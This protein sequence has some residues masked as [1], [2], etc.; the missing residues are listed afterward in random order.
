M[1]ISI[2]PSPLVRAVTLPPPSY[3]STPLAATYVGDKIIGQIN[4]ALAIIFELLRL[5]G[6]RRGGP[7]K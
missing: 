3:P 6:V 7:T 4:D 1:P 5:T 2:S